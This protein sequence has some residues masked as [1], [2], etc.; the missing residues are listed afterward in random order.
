MFDIWIALVEIFHFY[1]LNNL[2]IRDLV[3]TTFLIP[4]LAE[5]LDDPVLHPLAS[6]DRL[7]VAA[8]DLVSQQT[9]LPKYWRLLNGDQ[10]C[11]ILYSHHIQHPKTVDVGLVLWR[12]DN[13][14]NAG[15]EVAPFVMSAEPA[16][17][18]AT[19]ATPLTDL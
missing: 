13:P 14:V 17:F 8:Q 1:T 18:V 6:L 11:F 19:V 5:V 2:Y 4:R 16:F 3:I 7:T 10:I 12:G 9:T 15:F